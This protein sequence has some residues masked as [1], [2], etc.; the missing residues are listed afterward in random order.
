MQIKIRTFLYCHDLCSHRVKMPYRT[1]EPVAIDN[2][3]M[4]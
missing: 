4:K 1:E 2:M 3:Q